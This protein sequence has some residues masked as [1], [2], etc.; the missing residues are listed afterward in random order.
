MDPDAA[1]DLGMVQDG[2]RCGDDMVNILIMYDA[3]K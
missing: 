3:L 2:T 1:E